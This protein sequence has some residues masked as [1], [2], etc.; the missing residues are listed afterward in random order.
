MQQARPTNAVECKA[1]VG[2]RAIAVRIGVL[3]NGTFRLTT[4]YWRCIRR[5]FVRNSMSARGAALIISTILLA[6]GEFC[7]VSDPSWHKF[8]LLPWDEWLYVNR[9]F[10]LT[11]SLH[12]H[13]KCANCFAADKT[14]LRLID[15]NVYF[16]WKLFER[17]FRNVLERIFRIRYQ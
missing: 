11:G 1:E 10:R 13:R 7:N 5:E 12:V 9:A 3:S 4:V 14:C 6:T 16:R 15:K 8:L 17:Y 2:L